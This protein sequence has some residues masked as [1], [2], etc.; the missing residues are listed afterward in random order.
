MLHKR[1]YIFLL[2]VIISCEIRT[3]EVP[4]PRGIPLSRLPLYSPDKDFTCL[5]GS[6][7]IPFQQV[8]DDYCDCP[9]GT[10]E[11]G[12]SACP[13]GMFYCVNAG[14]KPLSI[15]SSRVN[16]GIC[17]CCDASDE[18]ASTKC[19]NNCNELGKSARIEAQK[20]AELLKLGSQIRA[21][22]S[23]KGIMIK[24]EKKEKL[25]ML[26]KNKNEAEQLKKEKETLKQE[27]EELENQAL[28]Q[29]RILEEE[30]KRLK[31]EE[32]AQKLKEE[33]L[34]AFNLFDSNKDGQVD[35]SELQTRPTFDRD[36]DGEITEEEAKFFLE[37]NNSL[38]FKQFLS[39]AWPKIKPLHMLNSGLFKPPRAV[40]DEADPNLETEDIDEEEDE[41]EQGEEP[42]R[43]HE[44]EEQEEAEEETEP[45]AEDPKEP[46]T[47]IEYDEDTK[48]LI[49]QATEARNNYNSA[50]RALRDIQNEMKEIEETLEKDY[51]P[52][53]EFAILDGQCFEYTDREYIYKLCPF[54]QVS[55]QPKSGGSDTRLGVWGSWVGKTN[56]YDVMLYERGASCWNGPQRTAHVNVV[57]GSEH[58][59]TSVSEPNR[60]E[61]VLDFSTPAACNPT[62][63]RSNDE[64]H[65]E[66]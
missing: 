10:D 51:G 40:T 48:K 39:V 49:D 61:Y 59:V 22:L 63:D 23:Q 32:E 46:E 66:L 35:I 5:D 13:H 19:I 62:Y 25:V 17:D 15:P 33:A 14:H 47:Q 34:D 4:R 2:L 57:C 42:D 52:D 65:D 12:T 21:E 24:Q 37:D 16:D 26:Q 64:L 11:P 53:E 27:I 6:L 9:D 60:C 58:V 20:R 54:D 8:N 18:Y 50:D 1:P 29:Y 44:G 30:Q 55:Q 3:S 31:Q 56:K 43:E 38:D 41:E 45:E 7:T 36:R 28:Q